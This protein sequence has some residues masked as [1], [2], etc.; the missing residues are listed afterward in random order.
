MRSG[1]AVAFGVL[2]SA[3]LLGGLA[4]W[5]GSTLLKEPDV[6]AASGSPEDAARGQQKIFDVARGGP[7]RGRSGS[8]AVV[9]SEAELNAFLSRNLVEVAK[10]PV[11]IRRDCRV[12][13]PRLST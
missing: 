2:F 7:G 5:A 8:H 13:G 1:C 4:L 11:T 10:M 9:V 6:I 3:A 12:Q